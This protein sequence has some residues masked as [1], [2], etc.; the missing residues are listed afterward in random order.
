[1]VMMYNGKETGSDR[2]TMQRLRRVNVMYLDNLAHMVV[3]NSEIVH[4]HIEIEMADG[5]TPK[6]KFTD[7]SQEFMWLSLPNA[8]GIKVPL[9]DIVIAIVSGIQSGSAVVTYRN[10]NWEA[11]IL[12]RKIHQSVASWFYGYW[13]HVNMNMG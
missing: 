13:T 6:H 4:K 8:D 12:I 2:I 1:M 9:F 10:D 7:L 5:S 11:V 3:P